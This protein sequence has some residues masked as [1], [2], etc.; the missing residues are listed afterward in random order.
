MKLCCGTQACSCMKALVVYH[1]TMGKSWETYQTHSN[2]K[3]RNLPAHQ[4]RFPAGPPQFP[5]SQ[6]TIMGP[7]VLTHVT[8]RSP[9]LNHKTVHD[10]SHWVIIR[11]VSF[12]VAWAKDFWGPYKPSRVSGKGPKA[13]QS[14]KLPRDRKG[15]CPNKS[16]NQWIDAS[17]D[18]LIDRS[19]AR[20]C[21]SLW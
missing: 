6:V 1:E 18:W 14:H 2:S 12:L 11:F 9:C 16:I 13:S 21:V 19:I 8:A 7:H 20:S 15:I 17:I 5:R 3:P 10:A 4:T